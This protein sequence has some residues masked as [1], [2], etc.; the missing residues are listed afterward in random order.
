MQ[1]YAIMFLVKEGGT[2]EPVKYDIESLQAESSIILLEESTPAIFLWHGK[3]QGLVARRIALRQAEALKGHG[4]IIGDTIIGRGVKTV[5]EID[6]RKIGKDPETDKINEEFQKILNRKYKSLGDFVA[7]FE[8]NESEIVKM[9]SQVNLLPE[10]KPAP[11]D[12]AIAKVTQIESLIIAEKP[13]KKISEKPS[14]EPIFPPEKLEFTSK[15]DATKIIE[16]LDTIENKLD[17]MIKHFHNFKKNFK[18]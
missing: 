3:K 13:S 18:K 8:T 1:K 11:K 17:A 2:I 9:E 7:V 14:V 10:I 15:L 16:H 5:K 4:Y 6:P 12:I